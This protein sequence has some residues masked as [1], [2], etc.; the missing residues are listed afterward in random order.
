MLLSE[1]EEVVLFRFLR[2]KSNH[3][4]KLMCKVTFLK[5]LFSVL[6]SMF[7]LDIDSFLYYIVI[8]KMIITDVY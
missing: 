4:A 7:I 1:I 6:L 8:N 2:L 5:K 3:I